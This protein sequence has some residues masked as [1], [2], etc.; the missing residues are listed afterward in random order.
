MATDETRDDGSLHVP[1]EMPSQSQLPTEF[2]LEALGDALIMVP[3]SGEE[4]FWN[5][6]TPQQRAAAF[7]K[8]V[9]T[10]PPVP[11]LPDEAFER[12]S[13]YD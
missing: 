12:E 5:R 8:W 6:A 13:W 10:C 2:K 3:A 7:R 9:A 1:A 4:P 11:Q